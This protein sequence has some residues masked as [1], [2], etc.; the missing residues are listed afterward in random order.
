MYTPA[1]LRANLKQ[2]DTKCPVSCISMPLRDQLSQ[3]ASNPPIPDKT[4]T[5]AAFQEGKIDLVGCSALSDN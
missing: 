3:V 5:L 4:Q 2:N 1:D